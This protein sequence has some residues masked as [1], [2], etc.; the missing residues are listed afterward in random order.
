MLS[1]NLRRDILKFREERD[2]SQFHNLRTLSTS[3]VLEA[4][5]LAEHTQ[6][7]RDSELA[8]VVAERKPM[9]E[10]EVADIV[11][12]LTYLAEDLGID[13]EHAVDE[14]LKFNAKRY[15][16]ELAKGS[17]RKYDQL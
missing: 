15:P 10:Q 14:K 8:A 4:A 13:V 11:I 3:I 16:V 5:E 7:A 1:E 17:A 6:W 12:L 2:W 9:I